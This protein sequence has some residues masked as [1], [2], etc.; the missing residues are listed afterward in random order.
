MFYIYIYFL[1]V[2]YSRIRCLYVYLVFA[3]VVKDKFQPWLI[4]KMYC[5]DLRYYLNSAGQVMR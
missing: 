2:F 4:I 5:I 1:Y 3:G